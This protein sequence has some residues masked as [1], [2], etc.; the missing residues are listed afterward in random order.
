MKIYEIINEEDMFPVG[1]L[2]Y[3]E[4]ERTFIIELSEELDEWTCPF[5]LTYFVKNKIYTIPR[6]ISRLWVEARIVPSERQNIDVILKNHKLKSYDEIRLLEISEGRCSQDSLAI[7]KISELPEYIKERM[8]KN[9]VECSII[10]DAS[11]LVFFGNDMVR[12]IRLSDLSDVAGM[13]LVLL[14]EGL[15]NSCK[16]GTG[17]YSVTFNDSIDV[18]AEVL[19]ERG[20]QIP[21]SLMDFKAFICNNTVDTTESGALLECSRQNIAYMVKQDQLTPVKE[22][23]KGNLYLKGD[24]IK[25]LW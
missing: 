21:L 25:N 1:V 17:G 10:S 13:D 6:E 3:F 20:E 19:Y 12:K 22:E 18:P 23:I 7:R 2:L 14:N 16:V 11:I 4:K 15:M 9:V 24:V 8:K 5:L